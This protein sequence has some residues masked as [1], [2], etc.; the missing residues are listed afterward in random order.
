MFHSRAVDDGVVD[1]ERDEG[2]WVLEHV[3]ED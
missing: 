3:R 1:E 2:W